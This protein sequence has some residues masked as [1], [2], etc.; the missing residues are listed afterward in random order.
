M[1]SEGP[2]FATAIVYCAA[3]MMRK[4]DRFQCSRVASSAIARPAALR[5]GGAVAR[6][7]RSVERVTVRTAN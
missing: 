7:T 4:L 3:R 6:A 2:V 5:G 1:C